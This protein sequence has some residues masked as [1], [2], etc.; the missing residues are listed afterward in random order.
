M[1][2]V[3]A[4]EFFGAEEDGLWG[5]IF[6]MGG[7]WCPD[8]SPGC[9]HSGGA[10]R[11]ACRSRDKIKN[12]KGKENPRPK[13]LWRIRILARIFTSL[14]HWLM[15]QQVWT[16]I[17]MI[18]ACYFDNKHIHTL[19]RVAINRMS[20][21]RSW[22]WRI[23]MRRRTWWSALPPWSLTIELHRLGTQLKETL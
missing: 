10:M 15:R 3:N 11:P 4:G 14:I 20:S 16:N 19:L 5:V 17:C 13:V 12:G 7:F 2:T 6:W 9:A 22:S 23:A 1:A 21:K 18:L 8:V